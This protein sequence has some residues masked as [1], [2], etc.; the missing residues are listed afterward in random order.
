M[1][2]DILGSELNIDGL[3]EAADKAQKAMDKVAESAEGAGKRISDVFKSI[4]TQGIDNTLQKLYDLK[5]TYETISKVEVKDAGLKEIATNAK[6]ALDEVNKLIEG[7]YKAY[8]AKAPTS[9]TAEQKAEE[10]RY[11]EWLRQKYEEEQ[12]HKQIEDRKTQATRSAIADQNQAYAEANAKKQSIARDKDNVKTNAESARKAY[13]EQLRIYENLFA[14]AEKK[15]PD[16]IDVAKTRTDINAIDSQLDKLMDR[17]N[18]LNNEMQLFKSMESGKTL[19]AEDYAHI[20]KVSDE[21]NKLMAQYEALDK[22][23]IAMSSK[24]GFEQAIADLS[25]FSLQ[26]QRSKQALD[27]LAQSYRTG[28]SAFHQQMKTPEFALD[29]SKNAKSIEEERQAIQL[30]KQA[31][32]SLDKTMPDGKKKVQE[33]TDAIANHEKNLKR[34]TQSTQEYNDAQRKLASQ[35]LERIYSQSP[36][37]AMNF[38]Q[39]AKSINDQ[40]LAIKRLKS[41]RDNLNRGSF[42]S[43]EAYRKKVAELTNEIKRQQTEVDKLRGKQEG[44]GKSHHSLMNTTDQLTRK[45]ALLFSVSAIQGYIQK[46]A[47]VR[48]EFEL[49]QRSLQAILQN[50]EKADELWGQ[51]L[52]LALKSPFRV[53]ELV[54]YTKQLA[55]YRIETDK[56]HETTKRLAD[57]SAGLGVDMQRLILAYGQV[58]AA[59]YLRGTELRQFTE[60]GIPMLDELAKYFTEMEGRTVTTAEVFERISKRMVEFGDVA[61]VFNRITSAGGVFYEMQEKQADTLH[62]QISNLH[63]AIDLMLNDIGAANDGM[64][65]GLVSTARAVVDNWEEVWLRMQAVLLALAAFGAKSLFVKFLATETGKAAAAAYSSTAAYSSWGGVLQ[66]M[67]AKISTLSLRLKSF[68]AQIRAGGASVL[69]TATNVKSLGNILSGALLRGL[70]AARAGFAALKVTMS[71]FL[72]MLAITAL[73][74]LYF[75]L[76]EASRE[77]ERLKEAL[78]G[79]DAELGKDLEKSIS[80]YE[81]LART[82]SDGTKSYTERDEAM[83]ELKRTFS[84]ILP[85]MYLERDTI[86]EMAGNYDKATSALRVYYDEKARIQKLEKLDEHYQDSFSTDMKESW[87]FYINNGIGGIQEDEYLKILSSVIEKGKEA[88]KNGILWDKETLQKE[89]A[90][91]LQQFYGFNDAIRKSLERNL[92][93]DLIS[94]NLGDLIDLLEKYQKDYSTISGLPAATKAEKKQSE[95]LSKMR[96]EYDEYKKTLAEINSLYGKYANLQKKSRQTGE[97]INDQDVKDIEKEL[98]EKYEKLKVEIPVSFSDVSDNTLAMQKEID[99]VTTSMNTNFVNTMSG[100][101]DKIKIATGGIYTMNTALAGMSKTPMPPMLSNINILNTDVNNLTQGINK[102]GTAV[103]FLNTIGK[104]KFFTFLPNAITD[105]NNVEGATAKLAETVIS[106]SDKVVDN[107]YQNFVNSIVESVAKANGVQMNMLN[108]LVVGANA[109]SAS[110]KQ[111]WKNQYDELV[112]RHAMAKQ[113]LAENPLLTVNYVYSLTGIEAKSE[114]ELKKIIK[115]YEESWKKVGFDIKDLVPDKKKPKGKKTD[116]AKDFANMLKEIRDSYEDLND[117]MDENDAITRTTTNWRKIFED[118]AKGVKGLNLAWED[119]DFT[120]VEGLVSALEKLQKVAKTKKT[121]DDIGKTIGQETTKQDEETAKKRADARDKEIDQLFELYD[122]YKELEKMD[123]DKD[124]ASKLFGVKATNLQEIRDSL[125]ENEYRFVGE[126][127]EEQYQKY[128]DKI[129]ELENK[130]QSERLKTYLKYAR[131]AISERAKIKIEEMR[132]LA[133]IEETFAVKEGDSAEVAT[134]KNTNKGY[135]IE[136]LKK[137]TQSELKKLEWDDFKQSYTFTGLFEDLEIASETMIRSTIQNL[138]KF[139]DEWAD[140]PLEDVKA[141]VDKI[142]QL[143]DALVKIKPF[144]YAKELKK[145]IKE[146][147]RDVGQIQEDIVTKESQIADNNIEIAQ[148]EEILRLAEERVRVNGKASVIDTALLMTAKAIIGA[149]KEENKELKNGIAK[150]E[151]ALDNHANLKAS[152]LAQADAVSKINDMATDL[153]DSFSELYDLFGSDDSPEKIFADMGMGIAQ[154]VLNTIALQLQLMAAQVGA[155]GLGA[156]LNT[157]MGIIGWIVMGVQ[158]VAQVLSSVFAAHD[159]SLQNQIEDLEDKIKSLAKAYEKLEVAAEKAYSTYS[160][161]TTMKQ[162]SQNID[163]QIRSRRAQ[164]ELEKDKK[165]TDKDQIKEWYDEIEELEKQRLELHREM[166][167]SL[168]GTYDIRDATREFVDAWVDAFNETGKGL[169]GLKENFHEFFKNIILEQAVMQG[170]GNIMQ[171]LLDKIIASLNDDYE[172]SDS[173]AGE[174]DKL[175]NVKMVELDKFLNRLFGDGGIWNKYIKDNPEASLSGLQEG[176]QGITEETAQIIE[177]Y[178]NSIRFYI[179]QD[180]QNLADLRNFFIGSDDNVNP[181]LAQLKIIATQTTAINSLLESLTAPHPTQSGR[182]LKVII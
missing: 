27:D 115:S 14:Q 52:Q 136:K 143:E 43:E 171:P 21:L 19:K 107:T 155:K 15:R 153:Y 76:T 147:G 1:A 98:K 66:G 129:A 74:E 81:R 83:Q 154:A 55:A 39:S 139:R 161:Q 102:T 31:R 146:D 50:K 121:K 135:A 23:K 165:D 4:S 130:E 17:I 133:E 173:E 92:D 166:I 120:T 80:T 56:L 73:V 69:A 119:F 89:L 60:A 149:K 100:F 162:A 177:A 20:G 124:V 137:D 16:L 40:I 148:Q 114:E 127:G 48:A 176:I 175:A 10:N 71:S 22:L 178:L 159:Q 79:V 64:M 24:S 61:E 168:G 42:T 12:I 58:R 117:W 182:G 45:L 158:I 179:A 180:N 51:T 91:A 86:L 46:L 62:G 142:N 28:T 37:L 123:I 150:D 144:A 54:S 47:S 30:L 134:I 126:E 163:E 181:M 99:R 63:D 35:R 95:A 53:K 151:K 128:L 172:I 44:L 106:E 112:A 157:A 140:M 38:S 90:D 18:R 167:E 96:K 70:N 13:E 131:D 87:R 68:F 138:Q 125:E 101:G 132:K 25:G 160:L 156:A 82:I 84:D 36:N 6:T 174:I 65:K 72:P 41:A 122:I 5:A 104:P 26:A 2:N 97:K 113:I 11:N 75:Q 141:M 29:F 164:I 7:L 116:P 33:L 93:A 9:T 111:T 109:T 3:I 78:S 110:V 170:A 152:Y 67:G 59:E 105:I 8:G 118:A 49:Q 77:A 108:D 34:A 103:D 145:A 57:V 88:A 94:H 85:S 169:S 32:E